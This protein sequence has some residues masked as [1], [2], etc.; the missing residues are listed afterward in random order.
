MQPHL[1]VKRGY[2]ILWSN[3]AAAA[4]WLKAIQSLLLALK[5]GLNTALDTYVHCINV[6]HNIPLSNYFSARV[7]FM[8]IMQ[9]HV[10]L[11]KFVISLA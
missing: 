11:H 10:W 8:Q 3:Y 4:I 1:K 5:S 9:G 2:L 7:I 6:P